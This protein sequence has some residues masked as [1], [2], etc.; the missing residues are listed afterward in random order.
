[1]KFILCPVI[2]SSLLFVSHAFF[3]SAAKAE[4]P[5]SS[6]PVDSAALAVTHTAKTIAISRGA[7]TV[8]VYNK[9]SPVI[10]D[11]VDTVYRRSGFL[12]PVNSPA[13]RVVTGVFPADHRHQNGVFSAWTKTSWN[14]RKIDF[15]NLGDRTGR[16]LHH[17][18]TGTFCDDMS[19]GFEVELVHRGVEEPATDILLEHWKVTVRP[20]DGSFHCFDLETIQAALTE[21][22]LTV[23]QYRYGGIALRGSVTWQH[24]KHRGENDGEETASEPQGAFEFLNDHGSDVIQGNHEKARWVS[25]IGDVD[26]NPVSITVLSHS[27]NFRAPQTAR[28]YPSK[29]Y[30]CFAPCVEGPFV[31]DRVHPYHA[32]YRYLITDETP[33]ADWLNQQWQNWCGSPAG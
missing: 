9:Q 27:E 11:G 24:P 25:L 4:D 19:A 26:G 18:I 14:G 32:R 33:D 1:M 31:I 21:F 5:A 16:V 23:H 3:L 8:L 7:V 2:F 22:P 17:R 6:P 10:P 12:H 29:P 15:W 20:T 13:G 28:L 30:F